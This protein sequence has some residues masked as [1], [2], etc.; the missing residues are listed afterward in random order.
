[1]DFDFTISLDEAY[2]QVQAHPAFSKYTQ[3]E[4]SSCEMFCDIVRQAPAKTVIQLQEA[5]ELIAYE[6]DNYGEAS[7]FLVNFAALA[8]GFNNVPASAAETFESIPVE[9]ADK[10]A[11]WLV[12][13]P[14]NQRSDALAAARN[15]ALKRVIRI[16]EGDYPARLN[17]Q[18]VCTLMCYA[19]ESIDHLLVFGN[20]AKESLMDGLNIRD[21][22]HPRL[23]EVFQSRPKSE[24]DTLVSK[25]WGE[26]SNLPHD[27]FIALEWQREGHIQIIKSK[28]YNET[29]AE[30]LLSSCEPG[31]PNF[32]S[33]RLAFGIEAIQR[34]PFL[35]QDLYDALSKK[36]VFQWLISEN[37]DS[38][39]AYLESLF[40]AGVLDRS[41][42]IEA[43]ELGI[44]KDKDQE[45]VV[46]YQLLK[47]LISS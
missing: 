18:H 4:W 28:G 10:F 17:H 11:D 43:L 33:A 38:R 31:D 1:M 40:V 13:I 47:K 26:K 24:I 12:S 27:F 7:G 8:G 5:L 45:Y 3:E 39:A 2:E 36:P 37:L 42:L 34:Y 15:L 6:T 41:K 9:D 30:F 23:W 35:A 25:W 29:V 20:Y 44:S 16:K 32:G 19:L 14:V 21:Q 22:I 46:R